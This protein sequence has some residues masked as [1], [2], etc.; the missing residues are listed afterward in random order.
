VGEFYTRRIS[1]KI[2]KKN[3]IWPDKSLV[4]GVFLRGGILYIEDFMENGKSFA[5]YGDLS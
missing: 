3:S 1:W 2:V 5:I 4:G